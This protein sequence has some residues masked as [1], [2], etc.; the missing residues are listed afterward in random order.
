LPCSGVVPL[1]RRALAEFR[2]T[3]GTHTIAPL[4]FGTHSHVHPRG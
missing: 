1:I 3:V 4:S 2:L